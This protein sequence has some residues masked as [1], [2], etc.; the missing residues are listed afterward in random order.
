M[1]PATQK[2]ILSSARD[3]PFNK[4][5][6][7]QSNVRR[8]KTGV[9]IEELAEDIARRTLLQSLSVRPVVGADGVATGMFEVPAGGRRYRALELLVKQKRLAKTA[10]VPCVVREAMDDVSAEEDS[11]AENVQRQALHPLD[12]FRSF[13]ALIDRGLSEEEI[14]ARF[15]VPVNVVKQRL[16]LTTVSER[17]LEIYADEG[18][19]LD[20]LT[21]FSVS[22]DHARQEQVWESLARSYNKEAYY[23]RRLLTE[24]AVRVDDRRALFVGVTAYEAAGGIVMRDLFSDDR[25]G[26]LQDPGLLDRLV[27]EKLKAET[28]VIAAEGWKWVTAALDF[29]YGHTNGLRRLVGEPI[30]RTEE[31]AASYDA[32]EAEFEALNEQYDSADELPEEVDAR[33]G[34]LETAIA[35]FEDRPLRYAADDIARAGVFVCLGA[36]GRLEIERGYVRPEDEAPANKGSDAD[37]DEPAAGTDEDGSVQRADITIGGERVEP[38]DDDDGAIR[39]LPDRLMTELTAHRT[40]ALR[41]AVARNPRVALTAL[42]HKLVRDAFDH[43]SAMGCLDVAVRHVFF[44]VQADDLKDSASAKAVTERHAG[45]QAEIPSNDDALWDWLASLDDAS[46]MA[47]LAHC[48][49]FG[50]NALYEK[51]SPYDGHGVS[52]HGLDLRLGQADRLARAVGLDMAEVGWRPTVANYLSRVTKARILEAVRE[53]VGEKAAQLV[54]HLKKGDMAKEAERLLTESGWLP[55]PLRLPELQ[56]DDDARVPVIEADDVALPAFLAGESDDAGVTDRD[57]EVSHSVAAE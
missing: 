5:V 4:L 13:K 2:I 33:L 10:L 30:D 39:P 44:A 26:W 25:G 51:P 18:M 36:E 24:S 17:L 19:T 47:L 50:V 23:I 42:L 28:Q 9:S 8:I 34:E 3:I 57:M 14:A 54:E 16:R 6:L 52:R 49:S 55:E 41:D 12:Q 53:G 56:A 40:L 45:W 48:V 46:R 1:A 20:Q 22:S 11:L 32:L 31:E 38:E 37:V 21:A 29:K 27:D 7:S 43:R 35:A 15:F